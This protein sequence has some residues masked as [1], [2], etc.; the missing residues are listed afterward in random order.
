MLVIGAVVIK[1]L[2]V[3]TIPLTPEERKERS[4]TPLTVLQKTSLAGFCVGI[5]ECDALYIIFRTRGGAAEYWEND[6]MRLLVVSI[7]I[8]VLVVQSL[9]IGLATSRADEREL[10]A[11]KSAPKFQVVAILVG[12]VLWQ[13]YLGQKFHDA[14]AVPIVYN[15]LTFGTIFI[16]YML[17][18]FAGVLYS[19]RFGRL[20]A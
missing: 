3:N 2:R 5:A 14:G 12:L 13:I 20:D 18:W 7:F 19:G 16:L 6:D 15:Y 8:G 4:S 10:R 1:N 9:L 17:S 11:I